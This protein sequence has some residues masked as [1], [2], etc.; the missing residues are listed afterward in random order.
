MVF[1]W[2]YN[3]GFILTS[4]IYYSGVGNRI[5]PL[6]YSSL[7]FL[8]VGR[9][10]S[11]VAQVPAQYSP[12]RPANCCCPLSRSHGRHD[13][14]STAWLEA[15]HTKPVWWSTTGDARLHTWRNAS[16]WTGPSCGS[17]RV[18]GSPSKAAHGNETACH[19]S[20]RPLLKPAFLSSIGV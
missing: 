17:S 7:F 15:S 19:V 8:P 13:G 3:I 5:L 2:N 9:V 1:F 10:A 4:F 12:P 16:I 11:S 14:F 6:H 20:R 18:S